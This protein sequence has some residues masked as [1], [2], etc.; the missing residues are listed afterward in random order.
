MAALVRRT[1][2]SRWTP[3][4]PHTEQLRLVADTD[5]H[6]PRARPRVR[7]P[8]VPAGRRS[9]KTERAKRQIV[10]I[11]IKAPA[12]SNY[13]FGAPTRDQAKRIFWRDIKL[14]VPPNLQSKRPS[15][16]MLEVYLRNGNML[17]V[18]G[19]DKPERIEGAPWAGGVLDEYGNMKEEAWVENVRPVLS[20]KGREGFCWLIGV[21]EG[22]NHYYDRYVQALEDESGE[23]GAYTWHSD[24][25]LSAEEIASAMRDMDELTFRQEYKAEFVQFVGQCY[26]PFT[27]ETHCERLR[28]LYN[29]DAT[30]FLCFD[31]NVD[32]GVCAIVQELKLPV[33]HKPVP[34]VIDGREIFGKALQL[35]PMQGT[36]VIGEVHIP[37]NSN[38]PAVCNKI[39]ADWGEHR[40]QVLVYGDA[41]GGSRGT[42]QTEGSDWDLVKNALYGQFGPERVIFNV[43]EANPT[44]RARIN[45]V[46]SR[47]RS[48]DGTIRLMV[49]PVAAP[50]TVT[51]FEGVRL[52]EGGSGEIDKKRDPKLTHLTDGIGYYVARRYPIRPDVAEVI[53]LRI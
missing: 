30:L 21:P 48:Q 9:G 52:L 47:L 46:N 31:F 39:I 44:E 49:D 5:P 10:K 11:A 28:Q 4:T 1:L 3:L 23:W 34:I 41:T 29:P 38:T 42:A 50:N 22:R 18:I 36:G 35:E 19:M 8:V 20:D 24:T 32:P 27:R 14:M 6:G 16:T 51:D 45:S 15:E 43:P 33:K 25:V 37:I 17:A 7:F 53:P 12:G 26:Y 13:F 2:T 40:G